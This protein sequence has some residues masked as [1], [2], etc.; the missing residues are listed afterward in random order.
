MLRHFGGLLNYLMEHEILPESQ[1]GFLP[2]RS[3]PMALD[4]AQTDRVEAKSSSDAMGVLAFD[5]SAAF[6]TVPSPH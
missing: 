6:D 2:G 5:L 1:F 3:V 4:Y